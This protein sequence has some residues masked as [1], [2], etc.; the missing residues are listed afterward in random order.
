[1]AKIQIGKVTTKLSLVQSI[2]NAGLGFGRNAAGVEVL[3]VKFP[4]CDAIELTQDGIES[5]SEVLT[6]YTPCGDSPQ[7]V[8]QR[9]ARTDQKGGL[10]AQFSDAKRS[11]SVAFSAEDREDVAAMLGGHL[12]AWSDYCAQLAAAAEE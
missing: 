4:G 5:L 10:V 11:R 9:T 12:D 7:A 3:T 2:E 6:A 8:F 1:M